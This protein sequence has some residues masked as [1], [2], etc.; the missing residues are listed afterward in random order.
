M[1]CY[2]IYRSAEDLGQTVP[3][4]G[5]FVEVGDGLEFDKNVDIALRT[6]FTSC[7]GSIHAKAAHTGTREF[8][9]VCC[10]SSE[11]FVSSH[12]AFPL[13]I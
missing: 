5:K 6:G 4:G 12:D 10:D 8:R 11:E 13:P 7:H 2:Q 3:Q 1:R 9:V